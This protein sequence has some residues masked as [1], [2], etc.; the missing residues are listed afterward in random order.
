MTEFELIARLKSQLPGNSR[1][2]VGA[3]DDCAVLD[4]GEPGWQGLLK[5]D[6]VVE[7]VHFEAS[8]EPERV[9]HKALARCLSD[10]AA[11]GGEATAAVVTLGLPGVD[12][13]ADASWAERAYHGLGK[14]AGRYGVAIVGGETTKNPAAR[15][16]S[17]ALVGRVPAGTALL[18][19]GTCAGDALFVTGE[20]GG[21][22]A[23]H[24]LDFEPRLEEGWWLRESGWV[25]A[26]I[27]VSDG[28]AGDVRHLLAAG[29]TASGELGAVIHK[30]ALPVSRA[31]VL[32]AHAG[33]LAKPAH[34][35]ALT[36]GEDFEL[37]FTVGSRQAV[38]LLD[39]WRA[40]FPDVRLSC[41]GK[42]TAVPGLQWRDERGVRPLTAGGFTHFLGGE[43]SEK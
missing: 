13:A 10:V 39:A 29:G 28:V 27:D 32:R 35:A 20:L 4:L 15:L 34:V 25:H 18:R 38:P 41:I 6:A 24:H 40:R 30:S 8:T 36:D 21:S 26:L 3:G 12:L 23:G 19:S 11:M 22:R 14:M 31:A 33:D 7:G 5:T 42:V 16:L 43:I 9:G 2:V 1:T 37:L 17:V